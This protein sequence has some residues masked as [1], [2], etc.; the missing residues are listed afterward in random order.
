MNTIQ[1]ACKKMCN[2]KKLRNDLL[3][4]LT[5]LAVAGVCLAV[6]LLTRSPGAYAAVISEGEEIA[7]YPLSE[8]IRVEI[9]TEKGGSNTLVIQKGMAYVVDS[10]CPD[11]LCEKKGKIRWNGE[12][13]VCLPNKLVIKILSDEQPE[14]DVI[15]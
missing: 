6:L 13:V 7:R 11:H 4:L 8:D 9:P 3:L 5:V 14:V 1:A 2:K 15:G 10:S 12:T